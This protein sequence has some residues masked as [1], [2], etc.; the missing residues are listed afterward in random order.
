MAAAIYLEQFYETLPKDVRT[1][2]QDKNANTCKQAGELADEYVQSR[3]AGSTTPGTRYHSRPF[4][5]QKCCFVC[6]QLGN[7]A[8]DC[9]V[10]K[11]DDNTKEEK[12]ESN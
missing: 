5:S 4:V 10:N 8:R 1:W 7:F 9:Q 6:T 2:V 11:Q 3:Q 12:K